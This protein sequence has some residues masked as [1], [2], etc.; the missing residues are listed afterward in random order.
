[1]N[2][3]LDIGGTKMRIATAGAGEEF[4]APRILETPATGD[5]AMRTIAT[6]A[7]ELVGDSDIQGV[8]AGVRA[9][10]RIHGTLRDHPRLPMWE[11][12]AIRDAL[13]KS[14]NTPVLIENDAAVVGLGEAVYGAGKGSTI[15]AYLTISTGVGGAKI[16]N[17]RIDE[18]A[19]GFEPGAE[20]VDGTHTLEE[21]ISGSAIE[22]KYGTHPKD[23]TNPDVWKELAHHLA[24]GVNN[25]IVHW[26]PDCV[27]L[28]GSMMNEI[29]IPLNVVQEYLTKML[30]VYGTC[31]PLLH[32]ALGDLGGLYGAL[33]L[34]KQK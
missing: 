4:S 12:F 21:L 13:Q 31:P 22:S 23:I 30:T 27:V 19:L 29:G 1:M 20:I 2:I 34:S 10:D 11:G 7:K 8:Y 3:L 15:V 32:A 18:N 5:E 28:G 33:A 17:G 24:I 16:S 25:A 14:F 26:S 9:Y 6:T